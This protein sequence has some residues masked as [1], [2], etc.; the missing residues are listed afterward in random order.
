MTWRFLALWTAAT[1]ATAAAFV[2]HLAV[3]FETVRLGYQVGEARR[4]Q[5]QLV[6]T[7]RLLTLESALLRQPARIE[8]FARNSLGMGRPVA[9]QVLVRA[10]PAEWP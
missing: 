6:E 7:W 10:L 1:V 5:R 3:R 2:M 4:E 9:S 8:E